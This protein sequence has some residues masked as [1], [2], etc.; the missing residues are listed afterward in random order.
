[1]GNMPPLSEPIEKG[2]VDP[3]V[4]MPHLVASREFAALLQFS[5]NREQGELSKVITQNRAGRTL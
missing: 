4:I 5:G 1:M 3:R 2:P